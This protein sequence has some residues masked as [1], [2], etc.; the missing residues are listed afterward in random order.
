[1]KVKCLES[2]ALAKGKTLQSGKEY[3]LDKKEAK[4][5]TKAGIVTEIIVTASDE[6]PSGDKE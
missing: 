3:D 1:M 6:L 5:L 2:C 4:S